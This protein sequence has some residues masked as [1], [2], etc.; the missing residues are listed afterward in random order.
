M[1]ILWITNCSA[2]SEPV[3]LNAYAAVSG[4]MDVEAAS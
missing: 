3:T 1:S 4:R 2:Y